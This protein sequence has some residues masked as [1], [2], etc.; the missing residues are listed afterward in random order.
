[1]HVQRYHFDDGHQHHWIKGLGF[2]RKLLAEFISREISIIWVVML[3]LYPMSSWQAFIKVLANDSCARSLRHL[4]MHKSLKR[5][6][7]NKKCTS[8]SFFLVIHGILYLPDYLE[9][10]MWTGILTHFYQ[11]IGHLF[12]R[13]SF[14]GWSTHSEPPRCILDG[15]RVEHRGMI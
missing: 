8:M 1:M 6:I 5:W 12:L 3:Y 2:A 7:F 15:L 14:S 13:H 10:L 11:P 4:K 9:S